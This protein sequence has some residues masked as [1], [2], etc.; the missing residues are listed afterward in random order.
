MYLN[1]TFVS[2]IHDL[3]GEGGKIWLTDI[4]SIINNLST[5]WDFE[6][7]KPMTD[8]SYNFVGLVKINATNKTAILKLSPTGGN[9]VSEMRW[10]N[11]IEKGAPE[12]YAFD[13]KLNAYL[14]EHLEPGHSLKRLV[15]AGKDDEATRIICQ[16]IRLIQSQHCKID[17]FRH[18][19]EFTKSL[20]LLEGKFDAKLLSKAQS[21]FLDLTKDRSNDVVLHGDLHHDNILSCQS[22]WKAIDPHGYVGDPAAEVGAMIRNADD[23]FPKSHSIPK[24][25]ER[26]LQILF[27]ELPFEAEKIKSWAFCI[28]ILSGAWSVE[29]HGSVPDIVIRVATAIDQA[30]I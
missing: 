19:S 24:I 20:L 7:L 2:N 29:D 1:P 26:R 17:S 15:K 18:L 8:L 23:C 16:T 13:E 25:V 14:M 22:G 28:T 3:Y 12:I 27:D 30:K 21:L 11:C 6:F 10:L 9:L 4:S 5:V